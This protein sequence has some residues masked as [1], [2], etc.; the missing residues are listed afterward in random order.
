[1]APQRLQLRALELRLSLSCGDSQ[2]AAPGTSPAWHRRQ[3]RKRAKAR[4]WL[5]SR[6]VPG[7]P[8]S[9]AAVDCIAGN[10]GSSLP[11]HVHSTAAG[12][13]WTCS[14]R[15][16]NWASHKL[17][18]KCGRLSEGRPHRGPSG[19]GPV[20]QPTAVPQD[21]S[22]QP[23]GPWYCAIC[24]ATNAQGTTLCEQCTYS[25]DHCRKAEQDARRWM[26]ERYPPP[27]HCGCGCVNVQSL[28]RCRK[29][30]GQKP[31]Y[32]ASLP[33]AVPRRVWRPVSSSSKQ[34]H[35]LW[36]QRT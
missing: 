24:E 10:H 20:A 25:Y 17:C 12:K 13:M 34:L 28:Q 30:Q 11:G 19:R 31:Q 27:W 33:A 21:Q 3:Q 16:H 14:C 26:L 23:Q 35:L 15:A 2:T 36:K 32:F 7:S 4:T 29:R 8:R 6:L 18:H 9:E 5:S 1:M 22:L